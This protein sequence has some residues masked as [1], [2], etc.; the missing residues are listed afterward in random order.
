LNIPNL[1]VP[2]VAY[3][4]MLQEKISQLAIMNA[5]MRLLVFDAKKEE[6]VRWQ[7]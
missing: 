1:A 7:N 3:N 2:D 4:E 5:N 6:I